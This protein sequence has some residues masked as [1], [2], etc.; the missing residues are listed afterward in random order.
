MSPQ[1]HEYAQPQNINAIHDMTTLSYRFHSYRAYENIESTHNEKNN[2]RTLSI[3]K[4]LRGER[5]M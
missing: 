4:N 3:K 5:A 1:L 2:M